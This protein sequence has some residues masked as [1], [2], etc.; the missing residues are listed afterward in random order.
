MMDVPL[1]LLG[2]LSCRVVEG[3]RPYPRP[4][5]IL[6]FWLGVLGLRCNGLGN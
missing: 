1:G 4:Y 3:D 6:G 2:C 5:F